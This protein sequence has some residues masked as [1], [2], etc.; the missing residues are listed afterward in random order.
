MHSGSRS[1][2]IVSTGDQ[3]VVILRNGI[4]IGRAKASLEQATTESQVLTLTGG[5]GRKAQWIQVGVQD[6]APEDAAIISTRGV[7]AMQL[8]AEFVAHMRSVMTPGTTVLVTQASV[9]GDTTGVQTTVLA[10]DGDPE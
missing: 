3:R 8:P 5:T 9:S 6:V 2:I 4:E 10:S 1:A 7:E